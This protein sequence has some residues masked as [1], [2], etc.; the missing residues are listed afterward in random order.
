MR[1]DGA[2]FLLNLRAFKKMKIPKGVQA[3]HLVFVS[4]AFVKPM[5]ERNALRSVLHKVT[6]DFVFLSTVASLWRSTLRGSLWPIF[7][8][9]YD[10]Y[11]HYLL[12]NDLL[13]P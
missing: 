4:I 12:L 11:K 3:V 8:F 1:Q 6:K 10:I 5:F 9:I 2:F 13:T 7:V